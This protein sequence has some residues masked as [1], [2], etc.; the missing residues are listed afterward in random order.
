MYDVFS[1][2]KLVSY[3]KYSCDTISVSAC[4]SLLHAITKQ[5]IETY[6][7]RMYAA[8]S[9][10]IRTNAPVDVKLDQQIVEEHNDAEQQEK[11]ADE[12]SEAEQ[13]CQDSGS[14]PSVEVS[15]GCHSEALPSSNPDA[16]SIKSADSGDSA[17]KVRE[18]IN[19]ELHSDSPV[20]VTEGSPPTSDTRLSI[21]ESIDVETPMQKTNPSESELPQMSS[22]G[23]KDDNSSPSDVKLSVDNSGRT[24][25]RFTS[26]SR[27]SPPTVPGKGASCED[28]QGNESNPEVTAIQRTRASALM[29]SLSRSSSSGIK[30]SEAAY[31]AA[32]NKLSSDCGWAFP[33]FDL[34]SLRQVGG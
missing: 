30:L 4:S 29:N 20:S 19:Q 12:V 24:L 14:K 25:V 5:G 7:V 11:P 34:Q 8:A 22:P 3:Y 10:W 26:G 16:V 18:D 17:S 2:C 21:V 6:T 27:S 33:V 32:V 31:H 1:T 15:V 9:D 23:S 28:S 13:S